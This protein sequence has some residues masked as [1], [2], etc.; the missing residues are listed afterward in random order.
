MAVAFWI[1]FWVLSCR[2]LVSVQYNYFCQLR[3]CGIVLGQI[4]GCL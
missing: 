3:L 1:Y 2:P 4:L